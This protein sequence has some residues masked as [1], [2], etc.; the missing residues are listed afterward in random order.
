LVKF[1]IGEFYS[2]SETKQEKVKLLFCYV[3]SDI[4]V[5]TADWRFLPDGENSLLFSACFAAVRMFFPGMPVLFPD[6]ST[7]PG[8]PG[9]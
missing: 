6:N 4:S 5:N 8:F 2:N 7:A 1:F 9:S 3:P